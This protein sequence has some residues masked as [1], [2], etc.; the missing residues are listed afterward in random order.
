VGLPEL[1]SVKL[2]TMGEQ[3]ASGEAVK[4]ADGTWAFAVMKVETTS[5]MQTT[6]L[7]IKMYKSNNSSFLKGYY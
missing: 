6:I 7:L 1:W 2:T 3:P 5:A 4:L